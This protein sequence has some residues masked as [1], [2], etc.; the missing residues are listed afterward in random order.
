MSKNEYVKNK[1]VTD[2]HAK[3][4][5]KLWVLELIESDPY[6]Y[7]GDAGN[8]AVQ[9]ALVKRV[10]NIELPLSVFCMNATVSRER[11]LILEDRIDLDKRVEYA[12]KRKPEN[13][14]EPF[15]ELID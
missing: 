11:N 5:S 4:I 8:P 2:I 1:I 7:G 9:Q 13:A 12:T 14:T 3:D 15:K 6:L 10:C